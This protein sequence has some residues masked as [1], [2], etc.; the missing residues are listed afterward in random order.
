MRSSQ[1]YFFLCLI[2][3]VKFSA[4]DSGEF[5]CVGLW[6]NQVLLLQIVSGWEVGVWLLQDVVERVEHSCQGQVRRPVLVKNGHM[7][8]A[9][10]RVDVE[11]V[12]VV[13]EVQGGRQLGILFGNVEFDVVGEV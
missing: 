11:V 5:R 1:S 8:L 10:G 6:T 3:D 13:H 12:D 7:H 2:A 4:D 9:S